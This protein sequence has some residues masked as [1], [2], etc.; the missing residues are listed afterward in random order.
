MEGTGDDL[1]LLFLSKLDEVYRLAAYSYR[2]LGILFGMSLSVKQSFLGENVDVQV[3]A[4]LLNVTVKKSHKVI[5]LILCCFHFYYLLFFVKIKPVKKG[6]LKASTV[7]AVYI[8]VDITRKHLIL[9][10]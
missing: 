3:V 4:A 7:A 9:L 2:K 5:Y 8:Y 1:I 6:G 10:T